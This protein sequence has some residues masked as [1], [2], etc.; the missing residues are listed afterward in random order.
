MNMKKLALF[1]G[2]AL[3]GSF[4][5]LGTTNCSKEKVPTPMASDCADTVHFST[6]ILPVIQNQCIGCHDVG[7]TSPRGPGAG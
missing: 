4:I 1:I 5:L 6:Q 3:C 7:G 2:V